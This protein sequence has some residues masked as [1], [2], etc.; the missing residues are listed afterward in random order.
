MAQLGCDPESWRTFAP[1][2]T[3]ADKRDNRDPETDDS[4]RLDVINQ[5]TQ[6][7]HMDARNGEAPVRTGSEDW[8]AFMERQRVTA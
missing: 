2:P 7:S 5:R 3:V 6:R 4:I 8:R 1:K